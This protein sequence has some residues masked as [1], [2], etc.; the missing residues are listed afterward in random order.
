MKACT[1]HRLDSVSLKIQDGFAVTVVLASEGYPGKYEKGKK[2][3]FGTVP[4]GE[5]NS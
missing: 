1:E 5:F 4:A 2:I 3:S